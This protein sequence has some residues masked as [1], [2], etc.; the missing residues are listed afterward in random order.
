MSQRFV[1]RVEARAAPLVAAVLVGAM[2]FDVVG[3]RDD[4]L[5]HVEIE[6]PDTTTTI[7]VTVTNA[8]SSASSSIPGPRGNVWY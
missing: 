3:H 4:S 2:V 6:L 7:Q 5:P 8:G 1:K